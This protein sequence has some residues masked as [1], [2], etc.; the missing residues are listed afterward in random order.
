VRQTDEAI[1][2]GLQEQLKVRAERIFNRVGLEAVSKAFAATQTLF[3]VTSGSSNRGQYKLTG[4][5]FD[6]K[7]ES[8]KN[9]A[10]NLVHLFFG[11][12]TIV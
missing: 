5:N 11:K 12:I 1:R 4:E 10:D 3:S 2:N 7:Q 6:E 8:A 9:I